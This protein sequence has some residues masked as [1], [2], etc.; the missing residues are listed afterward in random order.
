VI[1]RLRWPAWP[2]L[3]ACLAMAG[4]VPAQTFERARRA[5][6]LEMLPRLEKLASW[7]HA[8]GLYGERDDLYAL[9]LRHAPDHR[10]ARRI[11]K[12]KKTRS[13]GWVRTK[14]YERPKNKKNS[15]RYLD[16]L[17]ALRET[18]LG[19]YRDT[20]LRLLA[21]SGADLPLLER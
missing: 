4:A 17:T 20:M 15:D 14:G 3:L 8:K 5:A 2:T 10:R 11:L 16:E 21:E 13:S 6:A 18:E 1:S 19:R 7:C 9:L 12:Y